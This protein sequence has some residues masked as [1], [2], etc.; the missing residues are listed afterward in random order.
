[1]IEPI[2]YFAMGFLAAGLCALV[3]FPLV[4]ARGERLA[5]RRLMPEIPV[6]ISQ[7]R[8]DRD[9]LRAEF[10]M[11]VRRFEISVDELKARMAGQMV[12][13]GRKSDEVTRLKRELA[14]KTGAIPHLEERHGAPADHPPATRDQPAVVTAPR[15]DR[16]SL[17]E[18]L[19]GLAEHNQ[20]LD[21]SPVAASPRIAV[22]G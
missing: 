10:A 18:R 2:M 21:A 15:R 8:A 9:L 12:E 14:E 13:L 16:R 11:S 7:I 22:T 20:D 3:F 4:H 19:A 17:A 5:A 6:S 1:M